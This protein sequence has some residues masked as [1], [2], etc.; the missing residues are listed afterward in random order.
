M[1][2]RV[3]TSK[4]LLRGTGQRR[5]VL[6]AEPRAVP[7]RIPT[8]RKDAM[9]TA[10]TK[11]ATDQLKRLAA[12]REK[13]HAALREEKRKR[14]AYEDETEALRAAA[15][16]HHQAYGEQYASGV[17]LPDTEAAKLAGEIKERMGGKAF[18]SDSPYPSQAKLDELT[19]RYGQDD[20]E[21]R[22]FRLESLPQLVEEA[23]DPEVA[24]AIAA[25]L[26]ELID[27]LDEY[28]AGADR[29]KRLISE[30]QGFNGQHAHADPRIHALREVAEEFLSR[31]VEQPCITQYGEHRLA[32]VREN[33]NG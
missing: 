16:A 12:K 26:R 15:T 4:P 21:F 23:V 20:T 17:A 32:M 18:V 13:S 10:T 29:V 24:E 33:F 19:E 22:A 8:D 1:A 28:S 25:S 27:L 3:A 30:T 6:T 7:S 5:G 9:T 2:S 11:S 14:S 31:D